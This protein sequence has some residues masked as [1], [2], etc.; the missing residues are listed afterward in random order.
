MGSQDWTGWVAYTRVSTKEPEQLRALS[1]HIQRFGEL[2]LSADQIYSDV[3]SGS[4]NSR[5]DFKRVLELLREKSISG[6]L[7]ARQDRMVRDSLEWEQ[8]LR[9]LNRTGIPLRFLDEGSLDLS[10]PDGR[11]MSRVKASVAQYYIEELSEKIK[12][13]HERRRQR[14]QTHHVPF[15]WTTIDG[16][17]VLDHSPFRGG[18]TVAQAARQFVD[19]MLTTRSASQTVQTISLYYGIPQDGKTSE[20]RLHQRGVRKFIGFYTTS[21][22][23]WL[24]NPIHRGHIRYYPGKPEERIIYNAHTDR[25]MSEAEYQTIEDILASNRTWKNRGSNRVYPVSGLTRCALCGGAYTSHGSGRTFETKKGTQTRSYVYYSCQ[26][27]HGG[28]AAICSNEARY[29]LKDLE[30]ATQSALTAHAADLVNQALTEVE[31]SQDPAELELLARL[32]ALRKVPGQLAEIQQ[33]IKAAESQLRGYQQ[34][35]TTVE[36]YSQSF[37]LH[38]AE[39]MSHPAFWVDMDPAERKVIYHR[40]VGEIR[41]GSLGEIEVTLKI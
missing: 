8:I 4:D 38:W 22:R 32:D 36:D 30:S 19:W 9:E 5:S 24:R 6:V 3:G 18:V 29:T 21:F 10:R 20:E 28:R 35:R 26:S 1:N 11:F 23:A 17:P 14:G 31:H 13:G 2:G 12:V 33:L 41:L 34:Q 27:R 16:K 25:L 39:A 7:L 37:R 15:G 40:F